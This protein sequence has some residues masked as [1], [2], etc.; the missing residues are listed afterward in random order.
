[1]VLLKDINQSEEHP[2]TP[3]EAIAFLNKPIKQSQ[4]YN[5]L[6]NLI[7][8][9][10]V[11]FNCAENNVVQTYPYLG[12]LPMRILV[13]E[14]HP[15]NL[16]MVTLILT[17]LGLRAD[18]AGNGIEVL[19]ALHRQSYDVILMDVQM[20]EMDGLE[21]TKQI[22]MWHWDE[23]PRII[24]MT[25]NAM[26]GDK[27][28][29]LEAGMDDYISKPIR[30]EELV[31]V[32]SQCPLKVQKISVKQP[33]INSNYQEVKPVE[34][35]SSLTPGTAI[36][37]RILQSIRD[38]AGKDATVFLSE[39]INI[40]LKESAK[41]LV[42]MSVAIEQIDT[43]EVKQMAH[44]FKSSSASVGAIHL[45]NLCKN[46][47]TISHYG[48]IDQCRKILQQIEIEYER[49]KLALQIECC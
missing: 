30:L 35:L 1:L 2:D 34:K 45:S 33:D 6:L 4:L 42:A 20:P 28:I 31:R 7:S 32:L 43:N 15:V 38:M 11:I 18:V 17:K 29:C 44:K 41:I 19:S 23:Q 5:S 36:D 21:A 8:Q 47:E 26:Q 22:R 3:R 12:D 48:T 27:E 14:D 16:K 40:Y 46:M 25:A 49:V 24:A 13:A 10:P 37:L 39:V 9:Q